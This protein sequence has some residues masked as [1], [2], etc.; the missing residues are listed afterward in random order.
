MRLAFCLDGY[1]THAAALVRQDERGV[2]HCEI[3]GD[4][5]A[6]AIGRQIARVL[7]LD[8][9][10]TDYPLVAQR[11]PVVAKLMAARPGL[12]PPLFYS[13]YEAAAW[14]VLSARRPAAQMARVRERLNEEHGHVFS[15]GGESLA[16]FP[17]P[18]ALLEVSDFPGIPALKLERLH[19]VARAALE[20]R[21]DSDALSALAPQEA[22]EL[23]AELPGIGPF[24]SSLVVIRATASRDVLP[25]QEPRVQGIAKRLYGLREE[26]TPERFAQLA[27]PWR[28]WRTWVTVLMRAA[29]DRI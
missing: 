6:T 19:A 13:A 16:A 12:R 4:A 5:E 11:D 8:A 3:Q 29:G 17:T 20:G 9:D 26:V 7:S 23:V 22:M 27:E 25:P 1:E 2:V 15:L 28:P 18:R 24:Y 21:L 10:A 14:C